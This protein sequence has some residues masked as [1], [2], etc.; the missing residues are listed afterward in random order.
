MPDGFPTLTVMGCVVLNIF[1][2]L[3]PTMPIHMSINSVFRRFIV[4][5]DIMDSIFLAVYCLEMILKIYVFRSAYFKNNWDRLDFVI[6][7]LSLFDVVIGLN[8]SLGTGASSFDKSTLR[9]TKQ[10]KAIRLLRAMRMLRVLRTLKFIERLQRYTETTI[11]SMQQLG[12]ILSLTV[13]ILCIFAS[14]ACALFGDSMPKQFG[15]LTLTCFTLLQIITLDDWFKII[16]EGSIAAED[17]SKGF[18][19]ALFIFII[20]YIFAM[21]F[22]IFNLLLAVLV[23]NF[24]VSN[25]EEEMRIEA[26]ELASEVSFMSVISEAD[27]SDHILNAKIK[28]LL[29]EEDDELNYV[30]EGSF[31]DVPEHPSKVNSIKSD[32]KQNQQKKSDFLDYFRTFENAEN[33]MTIHEWYYKILPACEKHYFTFNNQ[34][35]AFE[36]IIE[37]EE[38][39]TYYESYYDSYHL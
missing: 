3:M 28:R 27:E 5:T 22:I 29:S 23:H 36:R 35:A 9:A 25:E 21:C 1:L 37:V 4:G 16:Q 8:S 30:T 20:V 33:E 32:P 18:N 39:Y 2:L 34:M 17:G 6:V 19:V 24:Q 38:L 12:P 14:V 31:L 13:S 26:E 15:N 10:F 7:W 11:T